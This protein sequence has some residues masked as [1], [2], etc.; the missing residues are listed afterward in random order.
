MAMFYEEKEEI[1]NFSNQF[2]F[3][4]N[5]QQINQAISNLDFNYCGNYQKDIKALINRLQRFLI[6]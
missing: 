4:Y 2:I 1:N 5:I 6:E 3:E